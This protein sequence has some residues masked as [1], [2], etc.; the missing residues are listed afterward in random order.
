[1]SP[2]WRRRLLILA[3]EVPIAVGGR[4]L[5]WGQALVDLGDRIS[6]RGAYLTWDRGPSLYAKDGSSYRESPP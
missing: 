3:G 1:M 2:R 6:P 5:D 4:L